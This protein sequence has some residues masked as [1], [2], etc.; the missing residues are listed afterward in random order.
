MKNTNNIIKSKEDLTKQAKM[1]E[2]IDFNFENRI[3]IEWKRDKQIEIFENPV[4]LDIYK[5]EN[6]IISKSPFSSI[7]DLRLPL[8]QRRSQ[9]LYIL[10]L[11]LQLWQSDTASMEM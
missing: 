11:F 5:P 8:N 9:L 2:V 10:T 6:D 7:F 4:A 3:Q 1:I